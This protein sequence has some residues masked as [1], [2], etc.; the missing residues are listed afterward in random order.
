MG[1]QPRKQSES[2]IY[3]IMSRGINKQL[4]FE[5]RSDCVQFLALL[6]DVKLRTSF[7][8][9]AYCLMGNHYHLL[10]RNEDESIPTAL[11]HQLN[12]SYAT[13]Y[14][15]K[16]ERCGH[17]FQDRFA[18]EPVDSDSYFLSCVRYIVQNPLKAGLCERISDYEF[19]SALDYI[20]GREGLT[21]CSLFA[22]M[23]DNEHVEEFL[24]MR[25]TEWHI[26]IERIGHL[27][28]D[29]AKRIMEQICRCKNASEFQML[30]RGERCLAISRMRSAGISIRQVSRITGTGIGVVRNA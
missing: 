17:L 6:L 19:S 8:L 14:N 21:D 23:L 29:E 3:H 27:S 5:D 9:F 20:S 12:S 24:S 16:Y 28:D 26:D 11:I 15:K 13:W 22:A 10:L 7:E 25:P 2:G 1:R 30:G 4:I 18:S